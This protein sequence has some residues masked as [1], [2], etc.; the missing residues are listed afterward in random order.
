MLVQREIAERLTAAPGDALYGGPSVLCALALAPA[1]RHAVSRS[2]FVP[3]P[4]VDSTLVAFTRRPEWPELADDWP[5]IVATVRAAFAYRRKTL[6]NALPP[7]GWRESRAA[8]EAACRAAGIDAKARAEA[9]P[10]ETFVALA[11][12][13]A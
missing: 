7:A 3:V 9:L 4:N 8:V 1:G 13:A 5:R 10:A 11:R 12:A 2:V 6:V